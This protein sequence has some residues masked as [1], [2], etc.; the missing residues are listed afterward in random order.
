MRKSL[1]DLSGKSFILQPIFHN[2][3]N[4]QPFW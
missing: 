2:Y 3:L 4:K 1:I